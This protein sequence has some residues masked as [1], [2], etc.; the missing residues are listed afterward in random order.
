MKKKVWR[1]SGLVCVLGG[2]FW[3]AVEEMMISSVRLV[4]PVG[5]LS[6]LQGKK[7]DDEAV[8]LWFGGYERE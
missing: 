7:D 1:D 5:V 3:C 8:G 2:C 6:L 4:S